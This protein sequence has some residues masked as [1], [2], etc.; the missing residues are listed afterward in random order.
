MDDLG[1]RREPSEWNAA[2]SVHDDTFSVH[3]C[4]AKRSASATAASVPIHPGATRT[5]QMPFG[6]TSFDKLLLYVDSAAL[7]AA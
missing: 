5:T 6:V 2:K 3:A 4:R 7:A 1:R